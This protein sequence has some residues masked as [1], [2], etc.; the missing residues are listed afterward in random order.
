MDENIERNWGLE[1]ELIRVTFGKKQGW[2][3][4]GNE[5]KKKKTMNEAASVSPD[6]LQF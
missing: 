6:K 3:W 1:G 5:K 4:S 2:K